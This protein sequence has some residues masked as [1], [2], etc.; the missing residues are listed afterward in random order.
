VN[1]VENVS[2]SNGSLESTL[3]VWIVCIIPQIN[4]P[5]RYGITYDAQS[6]DRRVCSWSLE[7]FPGKGSDL[8]ITNPMNGVTIT[9]REVEMEFEA[10][11]SAV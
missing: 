6:G 3:R 9:P 4:R 11:G 7:L 2:E 1:V 8:A 10:R 5:L